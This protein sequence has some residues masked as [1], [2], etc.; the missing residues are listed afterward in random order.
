MVSKYPPPEMMSDAGA[1]KLAAKLAEEIEEDEPTS[2]G[3]V[4]DSMQDLRPVKKG[5]RYDT[6]SIY[7]I[8]KNVRM[9]SLTG[10]EWIELQIAPGIDDRPLIVKAIVKID[11]RQAISPEDIDGLIESWDARTLIEIL[12]FAHEHC[13]PGTLPIMVDDAAKN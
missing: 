4:A 5:F 1:E 10:D 7:G 2:N 13:L 12:R 9:R 3:A 6:R 11:G 8:E